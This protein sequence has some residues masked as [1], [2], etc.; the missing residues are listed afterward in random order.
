V[1]GT[2]HCFELMLVVF[3]AGKGRPVIEH[4]IKFIIKN[5]FL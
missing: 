4:A 3:D 2:A 5:I 1:V